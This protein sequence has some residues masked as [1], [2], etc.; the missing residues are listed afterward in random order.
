MTLT[1]HDYL[2]IEKLLDLQVP[3]SD[4]AEHDETLFIVIHQTYELWFKQFLHELDRAEERLDADDL[5]GCIATLKRM[6]MVMKTLVQQV[7]ILETMTPLSFV[8]FRDRLDTASG[9]QSVQFRILEFRLGFKRARILESIGDEVPLRD[10]LAAAFEAPALQDV[11]HR[12]LSR[13][14][15]DI[16]AEVLERDVREAVTGNEAV[17]DELLRM[18][19]EKPD[20]SVLLELLTDLDEGL[21]EWRYRHVKL[22]ERTIGT[23]IGTGGSDGVQFLKKTLFQSLF[24]DLWAIRSRM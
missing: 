15:C 11:F 24:P 13:V 20:F 1:Y 14:G 19:R 12:F 22:A 9:L 3:R 21:Q 17:Q 4:P 2:A 5:W 6:R 18:Y 7:D 16:P 8:S 10:Q 23:K